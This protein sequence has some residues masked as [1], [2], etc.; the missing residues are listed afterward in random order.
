MG[1]DRRV[2]YQTELDRFTRFAES[3]N[4]FVLQRVTP[5][6][7]NAYKA[8]WPTL[9]P[10]TYSQDSV[11]KR[12]K[13]FLSFCVYRKWL[14]RVPKLAPVKITEPPTEPLTDDEYNA[15]LKAATDSKVNAVIQLMRCGSRWRLE[16][17]EIERVIRDSGFP[18][19]DRLRKLV[20]S[21]PSPENLCHQQR[22]YEPI[23]DILR[24]LP[25]CLIAD[26]AVVG[27]AQPTELVV[28][29]PYLG[30]CAKFAVCHR[31]AHLDQLKRLL[32][33]GDVAAGRVKA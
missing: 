8:T 28:L 2:K 14:D 22:D 31:P 20:E 11:Q 4:V 15:V 32:N 3:K 7:V 26:P 17:P 5:D 21:D 24:H 33:E 6:L 13:C 30:V 16:E 18:I 29:C 25:A 19:D 23:A 27:E 1:R 9:Y 10:S 12:L